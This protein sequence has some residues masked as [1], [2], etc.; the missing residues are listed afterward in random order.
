VINVLKIY[1]SS[2]SLSKV[3]KRLEVLTAVSMKIRVTLLKTLR[4]SSSRMTLGRQVK[5]EFRYFYI[6]KA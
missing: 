4:V 1:A 3:R 2:R 5:N 6:S